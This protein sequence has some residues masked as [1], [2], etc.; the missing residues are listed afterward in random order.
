[1]GAGRSGTTLLGI[2]L[3]GN[4]GI[5]DAGE[6]VRFPELEGRPHG[7]GPNTENYNFWKLITAIFFKD[8]NFRDFVYLYKISRKIEYHTHFFVNYF[9]L[10]SN[11]IGTQYKH[12]IN[13][14]FKAISDSIN[15]HTIIDSSKYPGR[16]LALNKY[17]DAEIYYIYLI[18]DPRAVVN[19]FS[20]K[21]LEQPSQNFIRATIYYFA[22]NLLSSLVLKKIK[23]SHLITIKYEDFIKEP[24]THLTRVESK[25]GF[26]LN[27]SKEKIK[28]NSV[29]SPG[30]I[31]EGNRL[32]LKESIYIE[33]RHLSYPYNSKYRI[34]KLLNRFWY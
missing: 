33:K 16:A 1:M 13:S 10:R 30:F 23:P 11:E 14:L 26:N 19:S 18:R 27:Q 2:I 17:L 8:T 28:N 25:F 15:D 6:L 4:K 9:N 21:G 20:K 22:I 12:Y 5:F 31:F 24:I 3:G 32:R 7:F 29:F 34:I